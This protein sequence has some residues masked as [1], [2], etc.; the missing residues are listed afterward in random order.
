MIVGCLE[1]WFTPHEMSDENQKQLEEARVQGLV[2]EEDNNP[3]PESV[4]PCNVQKITHSLKLY[5]TCHS[6]N[7]L[8]LKCH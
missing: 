8:T 5:K 7:H 6:T 4:K 3:P 2:E 1:N